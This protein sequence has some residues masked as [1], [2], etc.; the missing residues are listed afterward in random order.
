MKW[1]MFLAAAIFV[2]FVPTSQITRAADD[3]MTAVLT[4]YTK[5]QQVLASDTTEGISVAAKNILTHATSFKDKKLANAIITGASK[6]AAAKDI[7][8]ARAAFKELSKPVVSWAQKAKPAGF[9]VVDC[10]MAG[11]KW[12]QKKGTIQNPYYGKEMLEC[13][14]KVS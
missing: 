14:E 8:A 5:I 7:A 10:S 9:E 11:A 13:G 1:T 2:G 4:S 6:V 3:S 12:V